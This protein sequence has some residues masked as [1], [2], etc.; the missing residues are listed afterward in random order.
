MVG[1][2]FNEHAIPL[3]LLKDLAVLEEMIIEVAKWCYL[4]EHPERKRSP[5]GFTDGIALKLSGVGDGSAVPRLSLV[6]DQLQPVPPQAQCYFEQ[7]RGHL[8]GAINAAEYDEPINQHLPDALLAYFDRIGRGLREGE[9]IEFEPQKADRKA[10][11]TKSTRR[12]LVLASSQVLELTEEVTLRGTIP[13]ADQGKMTFELQVINGPR[14]VAPIASQHTQ[15]VMD[16]FNGYKQ[17]ARVLLQGIGRY[18]RYDRLQSL[19]TIEHLSLLDSNDI[20]A[21]LEEFKAIRH[22]WLD[23]KKGFA[24]NKDSLDWLADAFQRHYPDEIP[25]PYLYPTAEGGVQAEWSFDV[26]EATLEIDIDHYRGEWHLLEMISEEEE[27][28]SLNLNESE[29]WQWLVSEISKLAGSS[30]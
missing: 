22:G 4:Q 27:V 16:A 7:A 25:L 13:E 3:E 23:G 1:P 15:T 8:I 2:R 21:R 5:K 29:D 12:K 11:L 17:G 18:N 10:R 28:H 26:W 30:L 14:V 19:E 6:V 20:P 24:P 9:A